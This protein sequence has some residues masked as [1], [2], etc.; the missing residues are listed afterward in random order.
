MVSLQL[1]IEE[2]VLPILALAALFLGWRL[3]GADSGLA[4]RPSL[5]QSAMGDC[6]R[7]LQGIESGVPARVHGAFG[8][9]LAER[10][11]AAQLWLA[12]GSA[13]ADLD[14]AAG[15]GLLG[16]QHL[17]AAPRRGRRRR[18]GKSDLDGR[19][20]PARAC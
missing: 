18:A 4:A 8:T 11:A 19:A 10:P 2:P 17:A 15:V 13:P 1:G 14:L 9:F 7:R 12:T 16:R 5:V 3:I 20:R 6:T